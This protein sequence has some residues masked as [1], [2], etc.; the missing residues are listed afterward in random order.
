MVYNRPIFFLYSIYHYNHT[1][2][3]KPRYPTSSV[4]LWLLLPM[5]FFCD[6]IICSPNK[7]M[8]YLNMTSSHCMLL[9]DYQ[10]S[11]GCWEE[12]SQKKRRSFS[13]K[14][15]SPFYCVLKHVHCLRLQGIRPIW[16]YAFLTLYNIF[17]KNDTFIMP[18]RLICWYILYIHSWSCWCSL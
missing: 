15:I 14:K 11:T 16:S 3:L 7:S 17:V 10:P 9:S 2:T 5:E 6:V 12:K 1:I 4:T 8:P 13:L 18:T